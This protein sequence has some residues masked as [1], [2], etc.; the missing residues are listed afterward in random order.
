MQAAI[1]LVERQQGVVAGCAVIAVETKPKTKEM[2][3]KYKVVH[4]VP[5]QLQEKMDSHT[6]LG[7]EMVV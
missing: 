2:C 7:S 4:V 6:F 1:D 5:P 3:K